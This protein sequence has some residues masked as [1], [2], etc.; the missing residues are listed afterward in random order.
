MLSRTLRILGTVLLFLAGVPLFARPA[1]FEGET[2]EAQVKVHHAGGRASR[3]GNADVVVW[4]TPLGHDASPPATPARHYRM[5]QKDKRFRPH[6]LAVPVGAPVE[7]PNLDPWFH[8]VFSMYKGERFDLGL[9][10]AGTSRTVRFDRPGV[11]FIFCNIHPEMSAYILALGTPYFAVS[12]DLGQIRIADVPPGRYRLEAWFE[13]AES[14][15]M[16]KLS[17]EITITE[18]PVSLGNIEVQESPLAV[19]PHTDKRGQPYEPDRAPY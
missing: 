6:V 7:F 17:R 1:P 4:L 19:P 14:A 12:N 10:E 11:S 3:S 9:Y 18:T 16:S 5:V 8:N 13:R 15:E 2:V